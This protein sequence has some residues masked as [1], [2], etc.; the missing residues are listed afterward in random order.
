MTGISL[1]ETSMTTIISVGREQGFSDA[2][3]KE[4]LKG[5]GFKA[6]DINKAMIVNLDNTLFEDVVVP[7]EFGNMEGGMEQ[8][9]ELFDK[10]RKKLKA[11]A[12]PRT[13]RRTRRETAKEK[14]E[15]ATML[16][17]ANP[18]LFAMT[19]EEI[20]SRYPRIGVTETITTPPK[21]KSEIRAKAL[22]LL[23]A[24]ASFQAQP[25][26]TQRQLIIALDKTIGTR[27]N[28]VVSQEINALKQRIKDY[29]QGIKD[30]Q[31]AKRILRNY[32]RKA[33]PKSNLYTR[34]SITKIVSR[35]A[36][37]TP[38]TILSDVEYVNKQV[39]A[40]R[41]I[42][43][44]SIIKKMA[45]LVSEK[46]KKRITE[47]NKAKS[48]GIAAEAQAF[49]QEANNIF[50]LVLKNDFE[51]MLKVLEELSINEDVITQAI[52][53]EINGKK[54]TADE[55]RL[56]NLSYAFDNFSDLGNMTLEETT[57]LYNAFKDLNAEG[58]RRFKSRRAA[59]AEQIANMNKQAEV[60][61]KKGFPEVID[62]DG[63]PKNT[64]QL[65]QDRVRI[66]KLYAEKKYLKWAKEYVN[67]YRFGSFAELIR[68][69]KNNLKH[70][71]TLTNNLDKK[72][73]FF[74]DN[75]YRRLNLADEANMQGYFRTM[76]KLDD[77]ANSVGGI[78]KGFR[79]I[80]NKIYE[81]GTMDIKTRSTLSDGTMGSFSTTTLSRDKLLRIY[82]LYK[83]DVQRDKL[84]R[85]GFDRKTMDDIETFLGKDVTEF[86]DKM[87]YFLSN[88]Y[89]NETNDVYRAAN[90]V[91]LNYVQ[92]YF[93][94]QTLS[95]SKKMTSLL[96][97][98]DF[99]AIFNAESAPAL[100]RRADAKGDVSLE[101]D[102]SA[103]LIDHVKAMERYKAYAIP[104]KMLQGV[105]SDPYVK[106][107][108]ESLKV[109]KVMRQAVN[110]AIN[111]DSYVHNSAP[112]RFITSLQ[113]K[114]T[115][116]ALALKFMQIPKQMSSFVNAFENYSF[117]KEGQTPG[118][119]LVMF[120]VDASMMYANLLAEIAVIG[121]EKVSG[122]HIGLKSRPLTEAMGMSGSL[123]KRIELGVQ[124][125][126]VG[127]EAGQ[128]TFKN[129]E[130]NQAL[131]AKLGRGGRRLAASPTVIGDIAGV[132]G[133]MINYRR[134][135]KN[136]MSKAKALEEFN[137]YNATQQSRRATEKIPLQMNANAITR[138]L[139]MFGSTLFLQ[140][141]KVMSSSTNIM[142][143]IKDVGDAMIKGDIKKAK[144]GA[145]NIKIKDIRGLYLNLAVAN[146]MFTLMANMFKITSDD[147][148]DREEALQRMRDAMFGLNLL[149][150]IPFFE[151][152]EQ[153]VIDSRGGR[154]KVNAG[155]NPLGSIYSRINNEIKYEDSSAAYAISKNL[156]ELGVGVQFDPMIGLA[157]TFTGG[158]DEETMYDMLGVSY[159]Y[160]PGTGNKKKKS[161]SNKSNSGG[162][163]MTMDGESSSGKR[164]KRG[165]S[166]SGGINMTMD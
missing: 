162:I 130:S 70:L 110:Y 22:E 84:K 2:V 33:L 56:I 21:T 149:Y 103:T 38:A 90:D 113:S 133:Y 58:I 102:F 20:L 54:L 132:M 27:A 159:S 154:R 124:G 101:V 80:R 39:D 117:R 57:E 141:N 98:G 23:K 165:K 67:H 78:T 35:I 114:Y 75:V 105:F 25:E 91:N 28:K 158:F 53:K 160:R 74:T 10:I 87:V 150:A 24:E 122:K 138:S 7:V 111:P 63:N 82:S 156:L 40:Q 14:A 19:D 148:E 36:K 69:F 129:I 153:A 88:E 163:D 161:S 146:V 79:E 142:R 3:I 137:D 4:V 68:G 83:N 145:K 8:G 43:K 109:Q 157:E 135:I 9:Q 49:F 99:N 5:R 89:Y 34:G 51:G 77:I 92:N 66:E 44:R 95:S 59:R 108:L 116:F 112:M 151:F 155:V 37:A 29:Q 32:I 15:R 48:K 164:G 128:P 136:G 166:S 93:P 134:N 52:I 94:T 121:A 6:T 16:R 81:S 96:A 76:S 31:E 107:L 11:Y 45:K 120:M 60:E 144:E 85:Q 100:K 61:I 42:M 127:L 73:S 1:D 125:D 118:L 46:S 97:D 104:T 50:K 13:T 147:P 72:G 131:W 86:A 143:G 119:D 123:R 18:T 47:A 64:N 139:L 55:Q 71:G 12:Q 17:S 152:A 115:S 62:Q 26:T 126:L 140:M 30:I 106:S 41:E 65:A